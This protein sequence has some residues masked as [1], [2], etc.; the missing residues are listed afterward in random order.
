MSQVRFG[1]NKIMYSV[2]EKETGIEIHVFHD[3]QGWRKMIGE[4]TGN[5]QYFLRLR[6]FSGTNPRAKY[7]LAKIVDSYS[8]Y[9]INGDVTF[10]LR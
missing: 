6:N 1:E 8:Y 3:N 7:W 2:V 10:L 9:F 4:N 5:P